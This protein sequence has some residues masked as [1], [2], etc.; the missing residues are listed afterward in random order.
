MF[1][2]DLPI[3]LLLSLAACAPNLERKEEKK[4]VPTLG[5][6][7]Q[8]ARVPF[9]N[10]D[11]YNNED[12]PLTWKADVSTS[13]LLATA[14]SLI[15]AGKSLGNIKILGAGHRIANTFY[16]NPA[17]T[18]SV[19]FIDSPYVKVATAEVETLAKTELQAAIDMLANSQTQIIQIID[20]ASQEYLFP[21]VGVSE[22]LREINKYLVWQT[23]KLH[24][25]GVNELIVSA[26]DT[27]IRE[28]IAP[29]LMA[30][31][32]MIQEMLIAPNVLEA[33]DRL[34]SFMAN[35]EYTPSK[36]IQKQLDDGKTI[37]LLIERMGTPQNALTIIVEFWR[38]LDDEG[39]K[40]SIGTVSP[41]LYDYLKDQDAKDLRCLA[42]ETCHRIF[43]GIA[44]HYILKK[45]EAQG[46]SNLKTSFRE[47]ARSGFLE[48]VN[49]QIPSILLTAPETFKTTLIEELNSKITELSSIKNNFQ[50]YF[51]GLLETWAKSRVFHHR[52]SQLKGLE[53]SSV[54]VEI[55]NSQIMINAI[56]QD[57]SSS[58]AIGASL[59][60]ATARWELETL[61]SPTSGRIPSLN[62]SV[63]E[64]MNKLISLIGYNSGSRQV[65]PSLAIDL[66]S[67]SS[68]RVVFDPG[69]VESTSSILAIPD[70]MKLLGPFEL[71]PRSIVKSVGASNQA[72]LLRGVSAMLE[73]LQDWRPSAYDE[74]LGAVTAEELGVKDLPV[75][76]AQT[77]LFPKE[78]FFALAVANAA[79]VLKY[80]DSELSPVFAIDTENNVIWG[81]DVSKNSKNNMV[82]AG[83]VDLD[84]GKRSSLVST[85]S[86]AQYLSGL[87]RFYKA[88][89]GIEHTKATQLQ[90]KDASTGLSA[91]DKLEEV[92]GQLRMLIVGLS[93]LLSHELKDKDGGFVRG[94]QVTDKITKISNDKNLLDQVYAIKAL[95]DATEL[96]K[97][98]IY[99]WAAIDAYYFMNKNLW[100]PNEEFY[101]ES[102]QSEGFPFLNR[103]RALEALNQLK[104]SVPSESLPQLERIIA[105]AVRRLEKSL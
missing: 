41:E 17:N 39:R 43:K 33:I 31:Q 44:K 79:M 76:I 45:L 18:G 25:A 53:I 70:F 34:E 10:T 38:R 97:V 7:Q 95:L 89:D 80:L 64:Q 15:L 96:L 32:Q 84:K 83:I 57:N 87:I 50:D 78:T 21:T 90:E 102:S 101:N 30:S 2:K 91:V 94:L 74:A 72:E 4:V 82:M 12:Q 56:D 71:A 92:R 61:G 24:E 65:L 46:L 99:K 63:L 88:T 14:E 28:E 11:V 104:L 6:T 27:K 59:S 26:V 100:N 51:N 58:D 77:K 22:F 20:S 3:L 8:D 85:R 36:D 93:N 1:R 40:K 23:I 68:E 35:F 16:S 19:E 9:N 60:L 69:A 55:K 73:F 67:P 49:K 5:P 42:A 66:K 52:Q 47:G 98:P 86:M 81:N 29:Q 75:E 48:E 13:Q 54:K 105:A 103:V 37:G 62:R